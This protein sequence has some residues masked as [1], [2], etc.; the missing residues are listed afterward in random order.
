[1]SDEAGV[2]GAVA[3]RGNEVTLTKLLFIGGPG[4]TRTCNQTVMSDRKLIGFV[5]F[6]EFSFRFDRV[7]CG[8]VR[9]FLVRNW[10]GCPTRSAK[11]TEWAIASFLEL[12]QLE[13]VSIV[14]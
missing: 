12:R 8:L 6:A 11:R 3:Q 10:C 4:R 7:C 9:S 5:D 1:M 2:S 13:T 14:A